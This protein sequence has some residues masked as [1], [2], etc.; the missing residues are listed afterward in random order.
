MSKHI[1]RLAAPKSWP[2]KRKGIKFVTKP[3]PGPHKLKESIPLNLI[4]R[5]L[6]GYV[7]TTREA[8]KI[9]NSGKVLVDKVVRKD[10]KFPV[11]VMDIIKIPSINEYYRVLY[12][13]KGK[14][15]LHK[16]NK[17]EAEIKP[18]KIIGKTILKKNKTQ[19]NLYDGK[20]IIIK[21]DKYK[22][23]D[24]IIIIK[25]EI[26]KHL[27]LEKDALIYLIGGKHISLIGTLKEIHRLQNSP[28]RISFK[29][30]NKT[31]ETLK[32]Y[33]FVIDSSITIS[34]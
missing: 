1:S 25:D 32:K 16:I 20:N 24:S 31:F 4:L 9:L 33:A 19:L 14:F 26:K 21:E 18:E 12:N 28:D 8:K 30:D 23:G 17:Q 5:N 15:I 34:K 11:G 10:H 29:V 13:K 27:K 7:E 3:S 22:V 2:I 6:L